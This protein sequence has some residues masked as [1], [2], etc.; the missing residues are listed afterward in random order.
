ML[1]VALAVVCLASLVVGARSIPLGDVIAA[2]VD[3]TGTADH[4]AVREIRVPRTLVGLLVGIALGVGGAL[5]QGHT[6]NP[7]AD[8]G[9]LGVTAGASFAVCVGISAFGITALS[10]QVWIGIL[11]ALVASAVVFAV[12]S[13]VAG[14]DSAPVTL[15]LTGMIVTA[16]LTALTSAVLLL[17][18]ATITSFRF[19]TVGSLAG[20]GLD[21]VTTVLPFFLLGLLAALGG[22]RAL[23]SIALGDELA[24]SL[25]H[26]LLWD[27]LLGVG[28]VGLLTASAVAS[29]GPIVF[30]GLIAPHVARAISGPDYRWIVPLSGL[31]G[32]VVLVA[33]DVL[34]RVV[35]HPLEVQVGIIAALIGGPLFIALVRRRKLAAL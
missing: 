21:Q 14:R 23:N 31:I 25:G 9:I 18:S 15:A 7:L 24:A 16:I 19:W 11:G 20:R 35:I 4:I 8:P 22:S 12:G 3:P 2:L 30:I 10:G 29:A 6:R 17:D 27:R 28:A 34:G 32:A 26:R 5:M 13:S 33:A 1:L